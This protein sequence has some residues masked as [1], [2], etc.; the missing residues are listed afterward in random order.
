MSPRQV[1]CRLLLLV[2]LPGTSV[3]AQT[4][5]SQVIELQH[6]SAEA[7]LPAIRAMLEEDERVAAHGNQLILRSHAARSDELRQL[8]DQLDRPLQRLRISVTNDR[9]EYERQRGL[10]GGVRIRQA[11]TDIAIGQAPVH[12][13]IQARV[14]QRSTH[15]SSDSLRQISTLEGYPVLIESGEQVPLRETFIGPYG[16]HLQQNRYQ[17][18]TSG[19]YARV[20]L[21]GETARISLSQ[22]ADSYQ[23]ATG[24]IDTERSETQISVPLGQWVSVSALNESQGQ[25]ASSS[26]GHLST[27]EQ[28]RQQLYLMV[29][30]LP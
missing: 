28:G 18:V 8:I 13:G 11:H 29:E 21:Q 23:S 20:E 1:C 10:Q 24:V 19:F 6:G 5:S 30:R 9:S 16:Q 14:I 2:L 27:R 17:A 4:L 7:M 3:V 12:T 22:H 25:D 15:S 26:R